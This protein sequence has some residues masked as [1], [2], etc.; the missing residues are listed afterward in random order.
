M[1]R[2][3][4]TSFSRLGGVACALWFSALAV[5]CGQDMV[6]QF[7]WAELQ[8]AG[9]SLGGSVVTRDGRS[10]LQ[11]RN[12]N[13][14]PLQVALLRIPK[15]AVSN[16][17]YAVTGQVKYEGVEGIG[18]LEMWNYFPPLQPGLPE[19]QFFSR[20]LGESGAMGRLTGTSNWR[21]FQLPFD[22]TGA[23]GPPTRLEVNLVLPG[24]GVVYLSSL[25]LLQYAPG[26]SLTSGHSS[27]G[28]WSERT[29]G[30]IGGSGGALVGTLAAFLGYLAGRGRG[31]SFV[32][33]TLTSL[34][35]AGS[36]LAVLGLVAL[37]MHQPYAVWFPLLL[38]GGLLVGIL[39]ARLRQYRRHYETL[40]LRRMASLDT[41]AS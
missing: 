22:R 21:A 5:A 7:E 24:P 27:T 38:L 35:V 15:P 32:V 6:A 26:A 40:E 4:G 33:G 34:I 23:S 1:K 20:T 25:Q 2:D 18:F 10:V 31:R 8:K 13:R 11:V 37:A 17:V 16:Q 3:N 12:T 28:W 30:I 19:G 14:T 41:A 36:V 39:P 9:V 29:A